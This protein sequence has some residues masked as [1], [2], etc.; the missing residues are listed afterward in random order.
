MSNNY[1]VD[2]QKKSKITVI[3]VIVSV[4]VTIILGVFIISMIF[5]GDIKV[6]LRDSDIYIDAA[7]WPDNNID[8]SDIESV[9]YISDLEIGRRTNGLGGT[10]LSEGHFNNEAYGDYLLYIYN[11]CEA[12]IVIDTIEDIFVI[13]SSNEEETQQLYNDIQTKLGI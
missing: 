12:Y 7:Y 10:K 2:S 1:N 9:A 4:I 13:N 11:D 5:T 8:Y 3:A 6:E